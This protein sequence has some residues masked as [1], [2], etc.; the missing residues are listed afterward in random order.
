MSD[1]ELD[2][3]YEPV[4]IFLDRFD[5]GLNSF[6]REGVLTLLGLGGTFREAL[7]HLFSE[8]NGDRRALRPSGLFL[9]HEASYRKK[10]ST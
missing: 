1:R 8:A 6:N 7:F 10:Y 5:R 2:W 3:D 9:S 4:I